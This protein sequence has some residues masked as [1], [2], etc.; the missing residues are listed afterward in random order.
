M[1]EIQWGETKIG[2]SATAVR[3]RI[4]A[5]VRVLPAAV[6]RIGARSVD[7]APLFGAALPDYGRTTFAV[8]T[9]RSSDRFGP[10][11]VRNV[12]TSVSQ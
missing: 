4:T 7:Q 5:V 11:G 3:L 10:V 8:N 9:K 6:K 12:S 2:A 1:D